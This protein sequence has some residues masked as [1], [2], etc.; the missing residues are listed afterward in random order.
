MRLFGR[1]VTDNGRALFLQCFRCIYLSIICSLATWML[2]AW[3]DNQKIN[4][5]IPP[6]NADQAL[7]L[8]ARQA[9][10]QLLYPYETVKQVKLDGLSGIYRVEDGIARLLRGSCLEAVLGSDEKSQASNPYNSN[11]K[12]IVT[13]KTIN[14]K[15][16]SFISTLSAAVLGML[17]SGT[18]VGQEAGGASA[19]V[20]NS[21]QI[22]EIIVKARKVD[23]S[24]QTVP[25]SIT[26]L[27]GLDLERL[28]VTN[29]MDLQ[30]QVPNL[31]L[32]PSTSD[33]NAMTLALRGQK[34]NDILPSV[35]TSVGLYI[36]NVH[37]PRP[38]GLTGAMI[39]ID[40]VEVLRGP[41]GTLY[42]RN[43]TG[44]AISLFTKNPTDNQEGMLSVGVGNYSERIVSGMINIP[45]TDNVAARLVGR[46]GVRD[47]YGEDGLGRDLA[48]ED[49]YYMRGKIRGE[50]D[51]VEVVL[52]GI[53][54]QNDTGGAVY[55]MINPIS[56]NQGNVFQAAIELGLPFT[57]AGLAQAIQYLDSFAGGDPFETDSTWPPA[58]D[59]ESSVWALDVTVPLNESIN[60]RSTTSYVWVDR[61]SIG[62]GD[63]TPLA[64][65]QPS[66]A[67]TSRYIAQEFQ[68]QGGSAEFNWVLGLYAGDETAV[69]DGK[70]GILPALNPDNPIVFAGDIANDNQAVFAQANWQFAPKLRLTAGARYSRDGRELES[71]NRN[72]TICVVPAPGVQFVNAPTNPL[73]GPSQCPRK[74]KESFAEPSGLLSLDYQATDNIFAYG[75]VSYGYRTGGFN[76]RGGGSADSFAPFDPETVTEYE[77]GTKLDL[78]D[79]RVRFNLAVYHDDYNDVQVTGIFY[80]VNDV[81]VGITSNAA[82]AKIDGL[83]AE[84][85]VQP[86]DGL[87]L[88]AGVGW[89]DA[90]FIEFVDS[91]GDRSDEPFAVPE[92]TNNASASYVINTNFGS[93]T[94]SVDYRY[95]SDSTLNAGGDT[96][97]QKGYGLVNGR[98]AFTFDQWDMEVAIFGRN[99][100]DKLYVAQS[101]RLATVGDPRTYGLS[102]TKHFGRE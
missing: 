77:V 32:Q 76:F 26:A 71:E 69:E 27:S 30:N 84:L 48:D 90:R 31:V 57:P 58:S 45:L 22:D 62:D 33:N 78:F 95:Q 72:G 12:G 24:L 4:F 63:G 49:S 9:D 81:P 21:T 74:F 5:S 85:M 25:V 1:I 80:G 101:A 61:I 64:I 54:Q 98:I 3:G 47:G 66:Y 35:D 40:H 44:G 7:N 100:S 23:E 46:R 79:R 86:L 38:I 102:V 18:S 29:L 83:E 37:Y 43:T 68:L 52:S 73:N 28:Q 42:G 67:T 36:D 19:S 56:D 20:G 92:W 91:T 50:F 93:V 94:S 59:F 39:D 11:I 51:G 13:V 34:Q 96:V 10:M 97:Q 75:K 15:S 70:F 14:C 41:Q 2:P 6:S 60:F 88:T 89:T 82:E 87:T 53:Y 55:K 8:F 17:A 65:N 99:L 16:R